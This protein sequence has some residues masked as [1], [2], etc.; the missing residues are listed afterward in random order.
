MRKFFVAAGIVA[1]LY[2]APSFAADLPVKAPPMPASPAPVYSW[3]GFYVG[4]NIGGG[5]GTPNIGF[6]ANDP[7]TATLFSAGGLPPG[8]SL[9]T[10]GVLGGPQIGY[11]WQVNRNWLV[12]IESDFQWSGINGSVSGTNAPFGLGPMTS[13][14]DERLKWF[15]TARARLGYLPADRL[16]TYATGG[17]AYGRIDHSGSYVNNGATFPFTGGPITVTCIA[18]AP[19]YA[20]SSASTATGWTLGAGFE[21]ALS[22]NLTVKAEYLYVSLGATSMRE[23]AILSVPSP[24]SFNLNYGNS[25]FNVARVGFNYRY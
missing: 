9:T 12:G 25:N 17:F 15:G 16:L 5:W 13:M 19:C 20:G 7:A 14:E 3:T 1:A 10:S 24:A 6:T 2:G 8:G 22:N 4:A 11:N 23:T 18:G 21:Y